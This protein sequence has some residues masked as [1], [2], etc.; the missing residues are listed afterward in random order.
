MNVA[1]IMYSLQYLEK[2]NEY[3]EKYPP[4]IVVN[5]YG[6]SIAYFKDSS[7]ELLA[8]VNIIS[9]IAKKNFVNPTTGTSLVNKFQ[10][11]FASASSQRLEA[12]PFTYMLAV[13]N[14][15]TNQNRLVEL[16]KL[17]DNPEPPSDDENELLVEASHYI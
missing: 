1:S 13:H 3:L 16:E 11:Y 14:S 15:Y 17:L 6:V 5:I 12:N 4:E 10:G 2:I 8:L 9:T 7:I